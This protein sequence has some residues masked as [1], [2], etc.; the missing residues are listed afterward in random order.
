MLHGL[1][2]KEL[3]VP[4]FGDDLHHIILSCGP[5]ESMSECF[6]DDRTL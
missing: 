3:I 6:A 1:L 5:I 4:T 2:L